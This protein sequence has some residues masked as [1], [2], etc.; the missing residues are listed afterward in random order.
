VACASSSSWRS[1]Y[2]DHIVS[3]T[4]HALIVCINN[5]QARPLPWPQSVVRH[6]TMEEIL[7]GRKHDGRARSLTATDQAIMLRSWSQQ[8]MVDVHLIF[9][10]AIPL[11]GD[12][13]SVCIEFIL[14]QIPDLCSR[15]AV[16]TPSQKPYSIYREG[17]KRA[18]LASCFAPIYANRNNV[19][20][21]LG[22]LY[23]GKISE[24]NRRP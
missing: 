17:S 13:R 1:N 7:R 11:K 19:R 21:P 9:G 14:I 16:S 5:H 6:K 4:R 18:I 22:L 2:Q 3:M 20:R 12:S 23:V 8:L 15:L 24:V 10:H